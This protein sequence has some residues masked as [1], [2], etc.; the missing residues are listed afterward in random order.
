MH[1]PTCCFGNEECLDSQQGRC[2]AQGQRT[3]AGKECCNADQSC[4]EAG[5]MMGSCCPPNSVCGEL[6]CPHASDVCT[7]GDTQCCAAGDTCGTSD[8]VCCNPIDPTS[9]AP[10]FALGNFCADPSRKLCCRVDQVAV[11]GI[12]CHQGEFNCDGSCCLGSCSPTGQCV[13]NPTTAQCLA[14]GYEGTCDDVPGCR[15]DDGGNV[16]ESN[17]CCQIVPK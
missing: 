8:P 16:C 3:C 5:P 14:L 12:C 1:T 13:P 6:C 2:C 17:G 7:A 9:S 4:L 10:G 11:D 15:D